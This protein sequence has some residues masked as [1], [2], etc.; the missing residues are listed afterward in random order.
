LRITVGLGTR[1][2]GGWRRTVTVDTE[3]GPVEPESEEP[4]QPGNPGRKWKISV[5]CLVGVFVLLGAFDL[6]SH[7]VGPSGDT[8]APGK[9]SPVATHPAAASAPAASPSAASA[10]S[11]IAVAPPTAS[12]QGL[13]SSPA[14]TAASR[15]L[16]VAA[17]AAFGPEGTSDG[18]SPGLAPRALDD[19]AQ[20]WSSSAYLSSEFGHRQT[21]TG[22]LLDMG[23]TVT[24]SSVRLT[25]GGEPGAAVQVRVGDIAVLADTFMVSSASDVGGTV[26]LPTE[27]RAS[28]RYVL[29]GFTELPPIGHGEYQVS[30]SD[31][32]V[33][34]IVGS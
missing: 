17:I 34:G 15:P 28:G 30:V 29:I 14:A 22:L 6:M 25:L 7:G 2:A 33:D 19:G 23:K 26:R 11:P 4:K 18:D 12:Y 32:T 5:G 24:V 8:S 27:V 1:S 13:F 20:P 3:P 10:A 16:A 31:A 21:G 9:S